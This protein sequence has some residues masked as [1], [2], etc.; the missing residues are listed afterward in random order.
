MEEETRVFHKR[1]RKGM[2]LM[3]QGNEVHQMAVLMSGSVYAKCANVLINLQPGTVIDLFAMNGESIME[4]TALEDG[5]VA[6]FDYTEPADF[7]H[8]LDHGEE[9]RLFLIKGALKQVQTLDTAYIYGQKL[10]KELCT[11]IEEAYLRYKE[12]CEEIGIA[13]RKSSRME[14]VDKLE[15][16]PENVRELRQYFQ[17][18]NQAPPEIRDGLFRERKMVVIRHLRALSQMGKPLLYGLEMEL[19][20]IREKL[21]LL[22]ANSQENL[23]VFYVELLKN[24]ATP[25]KNI[26]EILKTM[27]NLLRMY[28]KTE[29]AVKKQM[30]MLIDE[31][32]DRYQQVYDNI[33]EVYKN[34][35]STLDESE[36]AMD[37]VTDMLDKLLEYAQLEEKAEDDFRMH[38]KSFANMK[39]RYSAEDEERRIRKKMAEQF[40]KLYERVFLRA[41]REGRN[42]V[43]LR[44]FLNYGIVDETMFE[45][46]QLD[47]LAAASYE[48]EDDELPVNV[49]TIWQ[50][51]HLIYNGE[52]EPSRNEF[53]MDYQQYLREENKGRGELTKA[54][55]E[56]QQSPEAKVHYEIKNFFQSNS[57]LT[58]GHMR[59]FCPVLTA[60]EMGFNPAKQQL[61]P[62]KVNDA[63]RRLL[64]VDFSVFY[65]EVMYDDRE[66]GITN[67]LIHVEVLPDIILMPNSGILGRMW[68]ENSG[69]K[70]ATS[71]RF[72]FPILLKEDLDKL[73]RQVVGS[74]RWEICKRV[75]GT[76]WNDVT[77]P[78]LT[79]EFCDYLQ[80]YRKNRDLSEKAKERISQL[81]VKSRNNYGKIFTLNYMAW[82]E[83]E[84]LGNVRIDKV[85]RNIL[86]RYCPFSRKLRERLLEQPM[87]TDALGRYERERLKKVRELNNRRAALRNANR[88]ETP[89]F[90]R[91]VEFYEL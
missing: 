4:Y 55:I 22:C 82:I 60:D 70:R 84:S 28:K 18:L 25:K 13:S 53:D 76:R 50:W 78:S 86:G 8:F 77:E 46:E 24:E 45:R 9:F 31:Q 7:K 40:Y 56:R 71:G 35:K 14:A 20:V 44:L 57:R 68:Q 21:G 83:S 75:Q 90:Q 16:L 15:W 29:Q 5:E 91:E 63:I 85:C 72:T 6:V 79:A 3:Q 54:E 41:E 49:Y 27:Q 19:K 26:R 67:L 2:T 61:T 65:R 1:F 23:F 36:D 47:E 89:E 80:F 12:L 88:E 58:N 42:N 52:R 59:T 43:V 64:D 39:D 51:L 33:A 62:R 87:F 32:A 37:D 34:V 66:N 73:M 10:L 74:F 11:Y 69:K 81:M 48:D 17:E 38:L 30:C